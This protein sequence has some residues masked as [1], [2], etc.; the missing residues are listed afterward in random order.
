VK[1]IVFKIFA[2]GNQKRKEFVILAPKGQKFTEQGIETLQ[3]Q[4]ATRVEEG[5]PGHDYRFV[6]VGA[7]AFNFVHEDACTK[8]TAELVA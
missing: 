1:K 3:S 5:F 6:P 4:M 8:C 2:P 7:N